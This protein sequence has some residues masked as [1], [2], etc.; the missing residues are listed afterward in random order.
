MDG[1]CYLG[2]E[3]PHDLVAVALFGV[4]C[5]GVAALKPP[6]ISVFG[7]ASF[8]CVHATIF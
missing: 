1:L 5:G 2:L 7:N 4:P 6:N 8:E 3:A